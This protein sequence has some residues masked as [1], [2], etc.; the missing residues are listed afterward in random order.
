MNVC[1]NTILPHWISKNRLT[2][3]AICINEIYRFMQ[4]KGQHLHKLSTHSAQH[5]IYR[6][7]WRKWGFIFQVAK[8]SLFHGYILALKL[9]FL[10]KSLNQKV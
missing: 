3:L 9:A 2:E 7:I 5:K 1:D 8:Y 4:R 6:F 10:Q